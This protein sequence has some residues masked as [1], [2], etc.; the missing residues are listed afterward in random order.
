VSAFSSTSIPIPKDWQE[1]ERKIR[2]LFE[3]LLDDP[4]AQTNGRV[5]QRQHGVDVFGTRRSNRASVGVQCKGRDGN[6]GSP[7][8]EVELRH[9]VGCTA[10]FRPPLNEFYLLTTAPDDSAIQQVARELELELAN[11]GR[12]ITIGVWGWH[13]VEQRIAQHPKALKEFLPDGTPYSGQILSGI[14]AIDKKLDL[15]V[16]ASAGDGGRSGFPNEALLDDQIDGYKKL[17]AS[18]K[19]QTGRGLLLD[20]QKRLGLLASPRIRFRILSNVAWALQALG[21]PEKASDLFLEATALDPQ[22]PAGLSNKVVALLM[23]GQ[24]EAALR[25]AKEALA[26]FP[27]H[28]GIAA[29][30]VQAR[31]ADESIDQVWKALDP[32]VRESREVLFMRLVA[33]RNSNDEMWIGES[34]QA[35]NR[36]PDDPAL[37]RL[38]AEAR[39][40]TALKDDPSFVGAVSSQPADLEALQDAAKALEEAWQSEKRSEGVIDH[41]IGHNYALCLLALRRRADAAII[42]DEV[43]ARADA[44]PTKKMRVRLFLDDNETQRALELARTLPD[45]PETAL[46]LAEL[47][48]ERDP[49]EARSLVAPARFEQQEAELRFAAAAVLFHSWS[50]S[51]TWPEAKACVSD[52]TQQFPNDPF[53][54]ILEYELYAAQG[55]RELAR[56]ALIKGVGLLS[57]ATHFQT[58]FQLARALEHEGLHDE[59]VK[60]MHG[61]AALTR[62]SPALRLLMAAAFNADRRG[63]FTSVLN[64]LA[65][66]VSELPYYVKLRMRF[67]RRI[68]DYAAAQALAERYL[69][70][71]PESLEM[72]IE[73]A[74]LL[75]ERGDTQTIRE[76][77]DSLPPKLAG[78]PEEFMVL[79]LLLAKYGF[80]ERA[81]D[82]AYTTWLANQRNSAVNVRYSALFLGPNMDLGVQPTLPH[83][84][85]HSVFKATSQHGDSKVFL[86][87]PNQQRLNLP[88]TLALNREQASIAAGTRAGSSFAL[89]NADWKVEWIKPKEIHALHTVLEDFNLNFPDDAA[90]QRVHLDEDNP[91]KTPYFVDSI[92]SR[93]DAIDNAFRVYEE[94][95]VPASM[96]AALLK[97]DP[98]QAML[99]LLRSGRKLKVCAG[100]LPER[101]S[102]LES[103]RMNSRKGC[104]VDAITLHLLLRLNLG[105]VV[106]ATCGPVSV[107]QHTL[108]NLREKADDLRA[109]L[110]E[111]DLSIGW[112][113]GELYKAEVSVEEKRTALQ[114]LEGDIAWIEERGA[115]L[116]SDGAS[117]VPETV[118]PVVR[119]LGPGFADEFLAA[120]T[121]DKLLLSD[122]F[123][124]RS[125]GQQAFQLRASW[126]QAVLIHARDRAE[127]SI[128]EYDRATLAMIRSGLD[129]TTIDAP[130]LVR[131]LPT[132]T[133]TPLPEPF[134]CASRALGGAF[135]GQESHL[136]VAFGAMVKFWT[137]DG[138]S[139]LVTGAA[140]GVLLD[141]ILPRDGPG[142]ATSIQMLKA[143]AQR[144]MPRSTRTAFTKY[145]DDWLRGH[146]IALG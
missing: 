116:A 132:A 87:E 95:A 28:A 138:R 78:D 51:E 61:H 105:R 60:A 46:I 111:P 5:G 76:R 115:V 119:K 25:V 8:T 35:A 92:K 90:L 79:A 124:F 140:T 94:L 118:R 112:Q 102:A 33:L 55:Q 4:N 30:R 88:G 15:V 24:K 37:R 80:A 136:R 109:R 13:S 96:I 18:G 12:S 121:H 49:A 74:S 130:L 53:P 104:V 127:V 84:S 134:L 26:A 42:C 97:T 123:G 114:V 68:G 89:N 106:E 108:T 58:R 39:L 146:F 141:R 23:K 100:T 143:L 2:V 31:A 56:E 133:V 44:P 22:N 82:L 10:S 117:D 50:N 113:G 107:V 6:F 103:I 7:I 16:A 83:V 47:L 52:V 19:P 71:R 129:F 1:F 17:I 126:L 40:Q 122:D 98:V 75:E 66:A 45:E 77:L 128:E 99:A 20:L 65:S 21:E 120:R 54:H 67:A 32:A 142:I 34:E 27:S 41:T 73:L 36:F 3:E 38:R 137:E 93:A 70:E 64:S 48:V 43:L 29:Q 81:R 144:E 72:L 139:D 125:L 62:D 86:I 59:A 131:Q 69:S 135:A 57:H 145:L 110:N 91:A 9:E 85:E 11:A 101:D 14:E 63:I